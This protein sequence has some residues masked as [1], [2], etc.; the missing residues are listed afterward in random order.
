MVVLHGYRRYG[1]NEG[2]DPGFTDPQL[3]AEIRQHPTVRA[4]WAERLEHAGVV[5]REETDAW[6]QAIRDRLDEALKAASDGPLAPEAPHTGKQRPER[7]QKRT[8]SVD[9]LEGIAQ[10][11]VTPPE[12][13]A[14]YPRLARLLDRARDTI[15]QEHV[16]EWGTAESLAFATLL[17]EG[18]AV[19]LAG[20][21]TQR[22]TF[23]QR[24]AVWHDNAVDRIHVPLAHVAGAS[25]SV[26]LVNSPLSETAGMGFEYGYDAFA[27]GTLVLWE[28]QFG[29]FANSGQVVIDNFLSSGYAK[30]QQRSG[31]VLLLPH[32]YD[33]QGP[34]H[35]SARLER[36]LELYADGNWRAAYPSNASQYFHLLR[37]HAHRGDPVPLIILTGKSLFR[38]SAVRARLEDLAGGR[39]HPVLVKYEPSDPA[40]VTTLVLGTGKVLVDLLDRTDEDNRPRTHAVAALEQICPWPEQGMVELKARYPALKS[41]TWLQEEPANMGAWRFVEEEFRRRWPN[42]PLRYV[43]R[44]AAAPPSEGFLPLHTE[45]QERLLREA[46][47]AEQ[48]SGRR[49]P[50]ATSE[51]VAAATGAAG[52]RD[53]TGATGRRR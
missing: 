4:L 7:G 22:G 5:S 18:C 42:V 14:V 8:W 43:G 41:I 27:P 29:D 19:R 26:A 9:D 1:H 33:G 10:G 47:A 45:T 30:W 16:V 28:A 39:F 31:L 32:G 17:A 44:S 3:D 35:S 34:E 13:F 6:Q 52:A 38:H 40:R 51:R 50:R 53:G 25:A 24:H 15:A 48:P 36:F 20:Q 23:S 21:D 46:W 2:D 11:L 12:G 49:V 37:E